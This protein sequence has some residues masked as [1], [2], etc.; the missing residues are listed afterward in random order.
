MMGQS[1][2]V[3]EIAHRQVRGT[4]EIRGGGDGPTEVGEATAIGE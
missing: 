2:E 4:R 1:D 3:F